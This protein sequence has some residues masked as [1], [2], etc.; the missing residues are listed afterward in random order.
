V[1][2]ADVEFLMIYIK[3]AHPADGWV[4]RSNERAG[5]NIATH[6]HMDDRVAACTLAQSELNI[7]IPA[8]VDGMDDA[9]A[10]EYSAWPDRIYLIDKDGRVAI[11]ADRGPRGF[12]PGVSRVQDWLE[13][14]FHE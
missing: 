8:L 12:P 5:I 14:R 6:R 11:K 2:K 4:K 13:T 1:Y 7:E 10:R 9:V 3:E